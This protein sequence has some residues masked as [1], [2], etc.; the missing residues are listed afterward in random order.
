MDVSTSGIGSSTLPMRIKQ[1]RKEEM[2]ISTPPSSSS[3]SS[4]KLDNMLSSCLGNSNYNETRCL[5]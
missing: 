3:S 4:S 2:K 5:R 1:A